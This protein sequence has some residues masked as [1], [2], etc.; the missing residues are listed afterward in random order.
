M[1]V[2]F[3]SDSLMGDVTS[4]KETMYM[5]GK[6]KEFVSD[7]SVNFAGEEL[8]G[9]I[10]IGKD[11]LIVNGESLLGSDKSLAINPATLAEKFAD[12]VLAQ[13]FEIPAE[14]MDMIISVMETVNTAYQELFTAEGNTDIGNIF[15]I[16]KY[17][18]IIEMTVSEENDSI[19]LSYIIDN[20]T[21]KALFEAIFDDYV[22]I[23]EDIIGGFDIPDADTAFDE[24]ELQID[25]ILASMDEML[26]INVTC[27]TYVN[28]KTA[29]CTTSTVNGTLVGK[30]VEEG[31]NDTIT[32][33]EK[34]TY[35]DD[36]I[37]LEADLINGDEAM[38]MDYTITK[39]IVND[40]VT[41]DL[42]MSVYETADGETVTTDVADMAL[43]YIKTS[44]AY[45]LTMTI[46]VDGEKQ[47]VILEGTAK[48]EGDT[49][50][51]E[52]ASVAVG[53]VTVNFRLALIFDKEATIPTRPTDALDVVELTEDQI[54]EIMTEFMESP[55]GQLIF[56]MPEE[57]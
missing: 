43:V 47:T 24:L 6:D 20:A 23:L 9:R 56:V 12:S 36:K 29:K 30:Q 26:E 17:Y 16:T 54:M 21:V 15:D 53:D 45:S 38:G 50:T 44:G 42:K 19:V 33:D 11:G 51:L 25:A 2:I 35:A 14:D 10:F 4:I 52:L 8:A 40:A 13:L 7:T 37:V 3:E 1:S 39:A 46:D 55:L 48:V 49:L 32:I 28:K 41:Y 27:K 5:N 34:I 31:E 22:K 18:D 57:Y